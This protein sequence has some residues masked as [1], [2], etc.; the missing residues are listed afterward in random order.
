M[1]N[2]NMK[3]RAAAVL[4]AVAL[5]AGTALLPNSS[6]LKQLISNEIVAEAV[7]SP[8]LTAPTSDN[9]YYYD[10]NPFYQAGY[11]MPNCTCYA[12]GRAYELLG[13][14]PNLCTGNAYNWFDYN[15]SGGYYP[16]GSTPKLGAIACWSGDAGHVGVVEAVNGNT[17][18]L[19]ESSWGGSYWY[20]EEVNVNNMENITSNFQGYIY[21][22]EWTA[23]T[24]GQEMTTAEAAGQTIP[25]GAYS[26]IS[27]L[28][29][30]YSVDIDGSTYDVAN[31]ANLQMTKN[32]GS[33]L[34]SQYDIFQFTY[35]DNGFY[36][37]RQ[38]GSDMYVDLADA[39]KECG[40]NIR[41][42][43]YT[44]SVSQQ[45][46][47]EQTS[48]GY[49]IRS[50]ANGFYMDVTDGRIADGTNL[51]SWEATNTE[52]QNFALIPYGESFGRTVD[53]GIY[54]IRSSMSRT[55]YLDADDSSKSSGLY[56]TG[57]NIQ[58]L[59][60]S[61]DMFRFVYMGNGYYT[62]SESSTGYVLTVSNPGEGS[63]FLED[64]RNITLEKYAGTRNQFWTARALTN[65]QYAIASCLNGCYVD[66][67]TSI[68]EDGENVSAVNYSGSKAQKWVLEPMSIIGDANLDGKLTNDDVN[69]LQ[70]WLTNGEVDVIANVDLNHDEKTNA[71]DLLILERMIKRE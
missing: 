68:T 2:K 58:I 18:V 66:L 15:K 6:R 51:R 30:N 14:K 40:A 61:T 34:P 50:R 1:K 27:E 46:S 16:Y 65:G 24:S 13:K 64:E 38:R 48:H 8:R 45:W 7:Y 62:I 22:G 63:R 70:K 3:R 53:E 39:S 29:Q 19:S 59:N 69:L 21:I 28:D 54:K 26:I 44:G 42:W 31:R 32:T 5:C 41:M 23:I 37:I 56:T 52:E 20:T 10:L 36:T 25:N 9:E 47:V 35:L 33:G 49:R 55:A 57:A 17:V 12:Y 71:V 67:E 11:G 43:E 4:S 60:N